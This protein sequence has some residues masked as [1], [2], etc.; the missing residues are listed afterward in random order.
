M[1]QKEN[2]WNIPNVL[3][4]LRIIFAVIAVYFILSGF[5]IV[6][7]VIAFIAG[8]LTDFFDGFIARKF[9]LKTEFGR[10]FDMIADRILM[11]SVV[12]AF[13]IKLKISGLLT[14]D[15]LLDIILTL[16]RDIVT[17]P[18]FLVTMLM[19]GSIPYVRI[20]GKI[21]TLM[22]SITL[23]MI[24]LDVFYKVFPI[25]FYFAVLTG[26]I[27]L[28]SAVYYTFDMVKSIHEKQS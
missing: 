4:F 8:A 17:V 25:S 14:S 9:N 6:Y 10:K 15:Y 5:N 27:G 3:T 20:V 19:G 28:V 26:A 21:T 12:L 23:P 11:V 22:Q 1:D 13:I 18:V 16:T 2:I 24:F 7:V